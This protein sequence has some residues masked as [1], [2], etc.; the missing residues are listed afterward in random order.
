MDR[1]ILIRIQIQGTGIEYQFLSFLGDGR[2]IKRD[3]F[4]TFTG[5]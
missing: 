5:S 1:T 2:K 4:L 3:N